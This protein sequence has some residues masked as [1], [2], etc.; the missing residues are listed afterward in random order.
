MRCEMKNLKNQRP[1]E[2]LWSIMLLT[3]Y[4][5][6]QHRDSQKKLGCSIISE[7]L[8]VLKLENHEGGLRKLFLIRN[9]K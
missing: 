8:D 1:S 3:G 5:E 6:A 2:G 7:K 4:H 9:T